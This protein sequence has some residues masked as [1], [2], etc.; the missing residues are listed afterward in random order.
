[1]INSVK[2]IKYNN[3]FFSNNNVIS[4]AKGVYLKI[5]KYINKG[6][7]LCAFKYKLLN[8]LNISPPLTQ[9]RLTKIVIP[10]I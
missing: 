4:F 1:M 8:I 9:G 2:D 5:V 10:L 6:V 3:N 7:S